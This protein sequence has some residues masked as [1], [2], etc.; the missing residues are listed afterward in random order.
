MFP[1]SRCK[2]GVLDEVGKTCS[3]FIVLLVIGQMGVIFHFLGE[4]VKAEK[5][6]IDTNKLALGIALNVAVAFAQVYIAIGMCKRC[7]GIMGWLFAAVLLGSVS[8]G[9]N[10]VLFKLTPLGFQDD[11]G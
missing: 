9:L 7:Q 4:L 2:D 11:S 6:K 1:D 10:L 5:T 8:S 3:G